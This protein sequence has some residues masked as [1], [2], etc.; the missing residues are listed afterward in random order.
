LK[1]ALASGRRSFYESEEGVASVFDLAT[2]SVQKVEEPPGI[3]IL[4]NLKEAGREVERNSGAS[5]I[6]LGDG[7]VCCEFHS[8]MNA[9]GAD[10]IAMS[11][12]AEA[13]GKRFRRHGHRQ[14]S[15]PTFRLARISCWCLSA[16]RS[17]SGTNCTWR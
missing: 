3:L 9:I 13:P 8:K 5:L 12:R 2:A 6:D 1:K 16:L 7:A 17:R 10:L 11:T 15:P 14:P 4:K